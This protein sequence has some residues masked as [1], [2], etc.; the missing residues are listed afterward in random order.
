MVFKPPL[1]GKC[2]LGFRLFDVGRI[3][4]FR[5]IEKRWKNSGYGSRKCPFFLYL[6]DAYGG[7]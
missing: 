1:R 6:Y 2:R 7:L 3:I 5:Q 4:Q